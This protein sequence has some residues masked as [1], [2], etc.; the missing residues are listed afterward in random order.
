ML[1]LCVCL[2]CICVSAC[3][4]ITL[5]R[6]IWKRKLTFCLVK[7]MISNHSYGARL[8]RGHGNIV[9]SDDVDDSRSVEDVYVPS[10]ITS[11]VEDTLVDSNTLILDD[12][13]ASFE[14]TS[15]S[16]YELV[17]WS[18]VYHTY[19]LVFTYHTYVRGPD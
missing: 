7:C 13:H 11:V 5:V 19:C 9:L 6:P 16:Q 2:S 3:S 12:V 4:F 14:G 18:I 10:E 17:E 8:E 1:H 15:D